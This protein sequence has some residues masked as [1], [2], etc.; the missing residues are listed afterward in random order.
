M[1]GTLLYWELQEKGEILFYK[2]TLF[3]GESDSY[4]KKPLE[5]GDFLHRSSN[6]EPGGGVCLPG[7]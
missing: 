6:G 3:T 2:K 7:L 5:T 1:E 4:V